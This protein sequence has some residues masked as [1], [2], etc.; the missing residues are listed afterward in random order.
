MVARCESCFAYINCYAKFEEDGW[1]CPLC[2]T[3]NALSPRY[4]S[5]NRRLLPE[6]QEGLLEFNVANDD[7][8]CASRPVF[9]AIVDLTG[10]TEA[11][12]TIKTGLAAVI[13][14]L[15][16]SSLFGLVTFSERI[17]VY[18][19]RSPIPHIKHIAIHESGECT[20][21]LEE[22]VPLSNSLVEISSYS[23]QITVAIEGLKSLH[24]NSF[25]QGTLRR[26]FGA[27]VRA[28]VDFLVALEESYSSVRIMTFLCGAP[29]HGDGKVEETSQLAPHT[30]FYLDQAKRAVEAGVCIDL[31]VLT[32]A[33]VGLSSLKFLTSFTGGNL[34]LYEQPEGASLPQDLY[35]QYTRPQAA[36][37]LFRLRTS[38]GFRVATAYGHLSA[39]PKYDNLYHIQGCDEYKCF[40]FDCVSK[41]GSLHRKTPSTIQMA[42]AYT[43]IP[44]VYDED[45]TAIR[46]RLRLQTVQMPVVKTGLELF[47]SAVPDSTICLL[48]HKLIHE[49]LKKGLEEGR[50]LLKDW[51]LILLSNLCS[52]HQKGDA[53]PNAMFKKMDAAFRS[54]P[55]LKIIISSV[56]S[57]LKQTAILNPNAN[58]DDI[59][60][61]QCLYSGL[62]PRFLRRVLYPDLSSWE[63]PDKL[64][65]QNLPLSKASLATARCNLFLIDGYHT[66]CVYLTSSGAGSS[67]PFPP[68]KGSLLRNTIDRLRQERHIAPRV[69]MAKAGTPQEAVFEQ[70]LIEEG[71]DGTSYAHFLNSVIQHVEKL[72][73]A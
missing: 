40:A 22:L 50:L 36:N 38:P 72:G 23:E 6:L 73:A 5:R 57:L 44:S 13:Q 18:D 62:E 30:A 67:G 11:L 1:C 29:N 65:C 66:I 64:S 39:D 59:V 14:A 12:E 58:T 7:T 4:A 47:V 15:P 27:A 25:V 37:G 54:V 24:S 69:V 10:T 42:F 52:H 32:N 48:V 26:G 17:G 68:P 21:G 2:H 70:M 41:T 31:F 43:Y 33:F 34:V 19:L 9:L 60:Y 56:Y 55:S 49:S 45:R 16:P 71:P 61:A 63:T 35:R 20:L 8:L 28:V 53:T 46:R 51:L 3:T